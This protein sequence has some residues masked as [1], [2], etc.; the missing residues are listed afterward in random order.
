M[1]PY[2][3]LVVPK[4]L[5]QM[6][7]E[8]VILSPSAIETYINCPYSWFV[9]YCVKPQTLDEDFGPLEQ[10]TF[11]H[12]VLDVFYGSL[13][14]VVGMNRI[15]P[16]NLSQSQALLSEV[17][18]QQ[19][20]LQADLESTR[21]VPLTSVERAETE[22]LK[23]LLIRNLALQARMMP[24]FA[25]AYH[26]KEIVLQDNLSYAGALIRGRVDR[27]DTDSDMGQ[28]VVIDYKGNIAGHDAGFKPDDI[29]DAPVELPHK[30][31]ALIYAQVLRSLLPERPVGALYLSYRAQE[32]RALL[33][34]SYDDS[35]LALDGF[36]K[37][38]SGVALNF[39]TYLD[40][41]EEL[42]AQPIERMK[43]GNIEQKPLCSD[44]C[45]Y[46]PVASCVRRLS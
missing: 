32:P 4:R 2:D 13:P 35:F 7:A 17:F 46:C 5:G 29:L 34:G 37:K 22:K 8:A 19:L 33:A 3:T 45:K 42:I 23:Q 43:Q 20:Q 18:D 31:Q 6:N 41:I 21:Y 39:G 12:G 27:I 14:Q 1:H 24:R 15:T 44:S 36:A 10:G 28:F 26:E 16:E 38:A 40:R 9:S 30:V 25:P 11:V